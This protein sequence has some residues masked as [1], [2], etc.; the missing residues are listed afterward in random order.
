[1]FSL[2]CAVLRRCWN[3]SWTSTTSTSRSVPNV[4]SVS[5]CSIMRRSCNDSRVSPAPRGSFMYWPSKCS[6]FPIM[7]L[8]IMLEF[9]TLQL[10]LDRFIAQWHR[11]L[12]GHRCGTQQSQLPS[13]LSQ[14]QMAAV[15][16]RRRLAEGVAKYAA[17]L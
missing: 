10:P 5:I 2:Q 13:D 12:Q 14:L 6:P 7:Y 15:H 16:E 4:L 11:R 9:S 1:M 3:R 17:A 8:E